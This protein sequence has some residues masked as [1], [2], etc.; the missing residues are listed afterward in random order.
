MGGLYQGGHGGSRSDGG[1]GTGSSKLGGGG[2]A[3]TTIGKSPQKKKS[4]GRHIQV[5]FHSIGIS[6]L[7][8]EQARIT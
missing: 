4:N 2:S 8:I 3:P 1:G 6:R 7:E 5:D